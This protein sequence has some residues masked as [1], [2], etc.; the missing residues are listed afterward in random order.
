MMQTDAKHMSEA[1]FVRHLLMAGAGGGGRKRNSVPPQKLPY[2]VRWRRLPVL[3]GLGRKVTE[4]EVEAPENKRF[5]LQRE[6]CSSALPPY[7]AH[8]GELALLHA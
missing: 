2:L 7:S 5:C 6:G 4:G 1:A 8:A 3:G